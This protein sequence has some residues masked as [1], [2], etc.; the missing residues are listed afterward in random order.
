M[1]STLSHLGNIAR[2]AL[3]AAGLA[4]AAPAH[5]VNHEVT[6]NPISPGRFVV[7]CSNLE[8][9]TSRMIPGAVPADYWEGKVVEGRARYI[10]ELLTQPEAAIRVPALVP[11][12][13]SLYPG[14]AGDVVE[15]VAI[16][17][18]PTSRTNTDPDY[19]L[20]GTEDKVPRMLAAGAQPKLVSWQEYFATIGV[21]VDPPM[22]G[23]AK[24]PLIVYSHGLSG[25]PI[26]KGYINVMTQLAAQGYVV[27]AVFHGDPRFSRVRLE[28]FS[29][30]FYALNNFDR[31]VEMMLMRPVALK[32]MTDVILAHPGYSQAVDAERIAGF[33]ASM[34]GQAMAHLL[35][36]KISA[37]LNKTC[38]DTVTDPRI[39]VA[40]AYVPYSGQAFLPAFCDDQRGAES[41]DRPFMAITGSF[42]T[43]A[44]ESLSEQAI[45]RMKGTRYMISLAGGEHELRIE[46]AGDLFTWMVTFYNAYLKPPFTDTGAMARLNRMARVN[47]GR[48]DSLVIDVHVPQTFSAAANEVPAREFHNTILD[49]YFMAAGQDEIDII[50]RGGAGPGWELTNQSFK[51]MSG[52]PSTFFSPIAPVCRFYGPGPNSHFF[53]PDA[54]ECN[55]VKRPGSGWLYEGVGFYVVP[56]TNQ[57][58]AAG[59]LQVM[60]AYNNRFAQNDSNHRYST[61][62]ST[63]RE[64]AHR[65]WAVE[66]TSWCALP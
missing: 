10:T 7:A 32:A 39:K 37:T 65:G 6:A 18:H 49:H 15:H 56:A 20:P 63:M 14:N 41:V 59:Q 27:A 40:L 5:A 11:D 1:D 28:D 33:G 29:D 2:T 46:D 58:C 62:D 9:D 19:T 51:V 50:L 35:G 8:M 25:S 64:M 12:I 23:P 17:C 47:G 26:G 57:G 36:A 31:I 55:F 43:T 4:V 21:E 30:Y 61:S 42:D 66:G 60:R 34:G 45:N 16:V 48:I 13:R 44:P 54:S 52:I 22:A 24:L 53:T 3:V 38:R